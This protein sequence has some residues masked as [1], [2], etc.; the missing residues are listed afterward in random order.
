MV[1]YFF[2]HNLI[3]QKQQMSDKIFKNKPSNCPYKIPVDSETECESISIPT[4]NSD[5]TDFKSFTGFDRTEMIKESVSEIDRLLAERT[6]NKSD[7]TVSV[8]ESE[9]VIKMSYNA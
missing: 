1:L 2:V 7:S 9:G 8:N 3:Q 4:F 5:A 6:K